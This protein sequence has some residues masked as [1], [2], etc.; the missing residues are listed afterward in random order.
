MINCMFHDLMR[1]QHVTHHERTGDNRIDLSTCC[2]EKI[3]GLLSRSLR[4]VME[5]T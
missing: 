2:E 1:G 3:G 4:T 5:D